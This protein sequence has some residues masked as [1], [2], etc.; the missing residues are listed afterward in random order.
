MAEEKKFYKDSLNL[1]KTSLAMK[2]N[3][4]QQEPQRL[5][6]WDKA[7]LYGEIQKLA[8]DRPRYFLHDG[9]PYANGDIHMGHLINKVLKDIVVKYRTM[10]GG[11]SPYIP[12]WDCHGLPIE[13]KVM[14]ELGKEAAALDQP[15]IRKRCEKYARKWV[16]TQGQQFQR[17][18]ILGDFETPYLTLDHSYEA[19]VMECFARFLDRRLVYRQK[20]PI[21]WSYGCRTALAEAELEYEDIAGPSI[22]VNFPAAADIEALVEERK[23]GEPLH[24]MIWTTTPWTL[25]A[26]LGIMVSPDFNYAAVRYMLHGESQVSLIAVE[27]VE[28]VMKAGKI[29]EFQTIGTVK[30]SD[31]VSKHYVHPF[32]DRRSAVLASE[33]VTLDDGTGLVHCAPGHG[34]EDYIVGLRHGLEPYSPVDEEAKFDQTVPDW[35]RGLF[36]FD[37]NPLICTRLADLG[38]LFAQGTI[39]HSYPHCW[40]SKTPVIFRATEQWFIAVDRPMDGKGPTLRQA[41]IDAIKKVRWVPAWGENRILGMLE[42]RPDWCVSRQRSWG[43]PV[44][45]FYCKKC[46]EPIMSAESVRQVRDYFAQHGANSWYRPGAAAAIL[47]PD[48]ACPKC[49]EKDFR[50]ESDILDVWFESGSSW[51]AAAQGRDR[52]DAPVELYLEGSDQHRGWFQSSLLIAVAATGAA[53]FKTVL[54]H[55]F[56]VDDQGKKMS[57]SLG[58]AVNVQDEVAKLG[59]DV[60]RLWVSS[61]DYQYDIRTSE[62]L[63]SQLQ[64]AYRKI[65][66]T[67]RFLLGNLSD[68]DPARHSV[69]VKEM[70]EL[71][72]WILA[73]AAE[74]VRDVRA[75]YEAFEFH[76][77]YQLVHGFCNEDLSSLYLDVQKDRMYCEATD[78]RER[79]S[80]Q[81]AMYLISHR[82]VRLLAPILAFTADE[83]WGHVPGATAEAAS[84]HLT[85]MPEVEKD[86]DDAALRERWQTLMTIRSAVM[87]KLEGLRSAGQIQSNM[88]AVVDICPKGEKTAN[89]LASVGSALLTRL[90]IVSLVRVAPAKGSSGVAVVSDNPLD[91]YEDEFLHVH[92]SKSAVPKCGRCWNLRSS[93]G[94]DSSQPDLCDRCAAVMKGIAT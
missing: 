9:P 63:I 34:Q 91:D 35:L 79:R 53:P 62:Q 76:R 11:R 52:L 74:V 44:P 88:E 73:R 5:K 18:G 89:L 14:Q 21:H 54:T 47:G 49:G 7:G 32:I 36:V 25:P 41:A 92:V 31:L 1:P 93:V 38:N 10:A 42:S 84:I 45:A 23:P 29:E 66:N 2:A 39:T 8:A 81:T 19:G 86:W 26:N 78:S 56:V 70:D 12:G 57:K 60:L 58:N 27:L 33:Y 72:R 90:F 75:A 20:K 4:I 64:D 28:R 16:K 83:I 15:E 17:L 77:V 69:P 71:D 30:G 43:V 94:Q 13:H 61:V 82:L 59:A 37:A 46:G 51:L 87:T 68:F 48:F 55:G 50:Q 40:R 3:L 85:P 65:R 24:L 67:F 80:G 22:Y 6:A